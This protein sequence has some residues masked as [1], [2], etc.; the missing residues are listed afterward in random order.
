MA[1]LSVVKALSGIHAL[2]AFFLQ[3]AATA[4]LT[5]E[6]AD[7]PPPIAM[8]FTGYSFSAF[9]NLSIRISIIVACN[10]A[11]RSAFLSAMKFGF[12]F[13]LSRSV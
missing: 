4:S 8:C 5:P 12:A 13:K 6:L 10:D 1:A 7:T 2:T 11:A 3:K 9:D